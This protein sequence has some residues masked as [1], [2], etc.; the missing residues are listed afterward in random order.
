MDQDFDICW[1][2]KATKS[3]KK[4]YTFLSKNASR[5]TANNVRKALMSSIDGLRKHP[6]R[7]PLEP[8]LRHRPEQFRYI[9]K[10]SYKIIYEFTGREVIILYVF[11]TRQDPQKLI[12]EIGED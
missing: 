4:I 11:H 10:W 8:N 1:D 9:Q 5:E 2:N 3:L 6:E 7:Y 12:D